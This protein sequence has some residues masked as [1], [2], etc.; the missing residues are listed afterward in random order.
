MSRHFQNETSI[1]D[2]VYVYSDIFDGIKVSRHFQNG[3]DHKIGK[4]SLCALVR[5]SGCVPGTQKVWKRT[6]CVPK[7]EVVWISDWMSRNIACKPCAIQSVDAGGIADGRKACRPFQN[8]SRSEC[9]DTFIPSKMP[10]NKHIESSIDLSFW[11]CLD[12][13]IPSK[14]PQHRHFELS[15]FQSV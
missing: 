13:F 7:F 15:Q 10:P 11:K 6:C 1:D 8:G 3:W 2:S 9:L 14:M 4:H 5:V 12:T